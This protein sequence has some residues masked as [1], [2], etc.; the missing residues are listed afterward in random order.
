MTPTT[1]KLD[2]L[3]RE[4]RRQIVTLR[5]CETVLALSKVNKRLQHICD[6]PG[7]FKAIIDNHRGH[8]VAT[9]YST[10]LSMESPI[11]SWARYALADAKAA[12]W[13]LDLSFIPIFHSKPQLNSD[14][15][16]RFRDLG[17]WGPQLMVSYR[18]YL[19]ASVFAF[20]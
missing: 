10:A 11:S 18:R 8:E 6:D 13:S 16:A 1:L 9:W 4:I 15:I 5:S 20:C 7:L 17:S 12:Q 14:A 19:M 2:W 3:P